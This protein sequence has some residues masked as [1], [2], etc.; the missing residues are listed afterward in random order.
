ML[1]VLVSV[2]LLISIPL[3]VVTTVTGQLPLTTNH[4]LWNDAYE[5]AQAGLSDYLQHLDADSSYTRFTSSSPDPSNPAFTGWVTV[6]STNPTESYEY[7]PTVLQ[8]QY[9]GLV[10]LLV[11]G[12]AVTGNL[13]SI[14]TISFR[15][16]PASS[17]NTLY[18]TNYETLDGRLLGHG[19]DDCA[20]FQGQNGGPSSGCIV[21][22]APGDVLDGPVFSNDGFYMCD[23]AGTAPTFQ[24]S[25]SSAD[26]YAD[27]NRWQEQC[28][29][30]NTT[31]VW[32]TSAPLGPSPLHA[33]NTPPQTTDA[34]DLTAA[35]NYGCDITNGSGSVTFTLNG[36]TLTWT[37]GTLS[38]ANGNPNSTA[39][40]GGSTGGGSVAFSA[41]RAAVI[42][43]SGNA[44][45][46]GPVNGALT[47]VSGANITIDG[48]IT[49]PSADKV[50]PSN[51]PWS[52]P[53]D[54]FGLI[55]QNSIQI[56]H[57]GNN[58]QC[59]GSHPTNC[60]YASGIEVDAALL[61]LNQSFYVQN[62]SQGSPDGSLSVFG[63]IAQYHR[64]PVGTGSSGGVASGYLKAYH[65]DSSLQ[66]V[67]P[68]YFIPPQ[69]AVWSPVAYSSYPSGPRSEAV[70][71][72]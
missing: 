14:Q 3:A 46:S 42:Y 28:P 17:L 37:G 43:T 26:A 69:G 40:C 29:G 60:D 65:Y 8:G 38:N 41:L 47:I 20:V 9:A 12:R 23:N 5:A 2:A 70:P 32:P 39:A 1:L 7:A 15:I 44:I 52:D 56:L 64:G 16:R 4:L 25:I 21:R 62:W 19:S 10:G 50:E 22:F 30:T 67:W 61:A 51:G 18:W 54:A 53:S 6:G 55:A 48:P 13:K 63:S 33:P 35:Q 72:T 45:V 31:P 49:Y 34:S 68:P 58:Q 57:A 24:N 36:S 27:P 59:S 11:S 71:G 66:T